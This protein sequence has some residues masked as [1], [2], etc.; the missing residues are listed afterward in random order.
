MIASRTPEGYPGRCPVCAEDV[1]VTPAD[2]LADAPCPACGSLIWPIRTDEGAFL[3]WAERIPADKRARLLEM[4][5]GFEDADSLDV[6]EMVMDLEEIFDLS[7][8]DEVVQTWEKP[9]DFLR[10]LCRQEFGEVD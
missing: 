2:A 7:I 3:A 8:P 6:V 1:T 5:A 4:T 9:V 10:W